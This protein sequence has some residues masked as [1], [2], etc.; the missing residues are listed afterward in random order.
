MRIAWRRAAFGALGCVMLPLAGCGLG[1]DHG[2]DSS[3]SCAAP[4][5]T[6]TPTTV[7]PGG[8]IDV[9]GVYFIDGCA[10]TSDADPVNPTQ[11]VELVLSVPGQADLHLARLNAAGGNGD[12]TARITIPTSVTPGKGTLRLGSAQPADLTISGS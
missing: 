3:A 2:N 11:H 1:S 10:D 12:I 4:W 5:L 8:Q 7:A 6:V 9:R